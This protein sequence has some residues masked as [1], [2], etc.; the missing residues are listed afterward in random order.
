MTKPIAETVSSFSPTRCEPAGP[1]LSRVPVRA[2]ATVTIRKAPAAPAL[3]PALWA[4]AGTLFSLPV[5]DLRAEGPHCAWPQGPCQPSS[6]CAHVGP[7]RAPARPPRCVPDP[8]PPSAHPPTPCSP[9]APTP[10]R[11]CAHPA[12]S[13]GSGDAPLA[14]G[15]TAACAAR[16]PAAERAPQG[17]VALTTGRWPVPSSSVIF[18]V[19]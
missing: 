4:A 2:P 9:P 17:S 8:T 1:P 15:L 18:V 12:R 14:A 7:I 19:M 6:L 3:R 10:A 5:L 16:P 13:R 11:D